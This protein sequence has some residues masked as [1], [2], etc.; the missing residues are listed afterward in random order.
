MD[1]CTFAYLD[2]ANVPGVGSLLLDPRPSFVLA[3]DGRQVLWANAAGASFLDERRMGDVLRRRFSDLNP[4]R[5]QV[6]RLS[7]LLPDDT[8]RLEVLRFGRGVALDAVPAACR[9]LNLSRDTRA[10]LATVIAG[11]AAESIT[12]RAERLVD[13]IGA[14][15]KSVV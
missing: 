11:G 10:V 8:S 15:R 7:R 9:R 5:H 13:G 4:I 12:A 1:R 6:A 14:D 3:S 2:V